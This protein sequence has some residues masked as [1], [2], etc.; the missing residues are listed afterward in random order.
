M[1]TA[2]RRTLIAGAAASRRPG[3]AAARDPLAAIEAEVGGR[4]GVAALDV[5]TGQRLFWRGGERFPMCSTF[6][7]LAVAALLKRV[8]PGQDRLDRFVRF[9]DS[10]PAQLCARDHAPTSPRAA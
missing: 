8:D 4:L 5:A 2:S 9:G 10:R 6:K 7:V 1:L 3:L